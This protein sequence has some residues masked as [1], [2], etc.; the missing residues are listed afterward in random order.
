[1]IC[2]SCKTEITPKVVKREGY[3]NGKKVYYVHTE[4]PNCGN[5]LQKK[6]TEPRS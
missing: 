5:V 3:E 4:C 2:P 1:M 6:P